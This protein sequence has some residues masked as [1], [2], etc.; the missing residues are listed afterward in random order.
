MIRE[1]WFL[2]RNGENR[3]WNV[4]IG[5]KLEMIVV[6]N[7]FG[8]VIIASINIIIQTSSSSSSLICN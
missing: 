7:D 4:K 3:L 2:P 1:L 5:I 6:G 8:N